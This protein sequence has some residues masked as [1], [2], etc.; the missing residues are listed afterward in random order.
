MWGCEIK[1]THLI[2]DHVVIY[3]LIMIIANMRLHYS[4]FVCCKKCE[5]LNYH[6]SWHEVIKIY[7]D[8]LCLIYPDFLNYFDCNRMLDFDILLKI[9]IVVSSYILLYVINLSCSYIYI[10][11]DY[12]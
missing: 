11:Y 4:F 5:N 6:I 12:S 3:I 7:W 8:I 1:C 9:I 10:D 2:I